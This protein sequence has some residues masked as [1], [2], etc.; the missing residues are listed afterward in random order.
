[1]MPVSPE[2]RLAHLGFV[3][4]PPTPALRPFI[5]SYWGMR[6]AHALAVAPEFMHPG[7][8]FGLGFDFGGGLAL[9]SQ[10]ITDPV[11][12]DGTNT[13]SR[14]MSFTGAV[15]VLG[16][17]FHPGAAYPFL[18]IPLVEL[19]N[20]TELMGAVGQRPLLLLHEQ[21]A[22]APTLTAKIARLEAWL[23]ARLQPTASPYVLHSL[24]QIKQHAG[25]LDMKRIADDLYI[26]QRQLERLYQIHV[27]MTPKH[28][29][30]LQ[31]VEAARL[32]LKQANGVSLAH[33]SAEFAYYDQAHFTH[34]FK[35]VVGLTPRDYLRTHP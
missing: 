15:D 26:S 13:I 32:A 21:M 16:I 2:E 27:G 35:A 28:F 5:A 30:R 23:L 4:V 29:A 25:Q 6:R 8:G 33:I 9:D 3:L 20:S 12:L 17:R 34:E 1:M 7:G 22:E 14:R 10:P 11:F 24:Y 19:A 31:R 18:G